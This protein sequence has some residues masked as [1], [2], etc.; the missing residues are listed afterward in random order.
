[1]NM[2]SRILKCSIKESNIPGFH[3]KSNVVTLGFQ[4]YREWFEN[5]ILHQNPLRPQTVVPQLFRYQIHSV[6][7]GAGFEILHF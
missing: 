3:E 4:Y 1:M 6:D 7:Q 5:V 2:H